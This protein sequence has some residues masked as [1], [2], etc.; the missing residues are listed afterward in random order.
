VRRAAPSPDADLSAQWEVV[1]AFLAASRGGDFQ[2]L[3]AVLDPDVVLRA[4]GGLRAISSHVQGAETVASQ[5]LTWSRV[6]L[7][8]HR[9]LVNG[10]PGFIALRDGRPFS[11]GAFT[12]RG[13]RIVEFDILADPDRLSQLDLTV[14]RD[15][16]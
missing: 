15:S 11:V 14:L 13:G 4:D 8:L 3:V 10:A 7:T 12:V 9:A 5:A 1:D 6:D 2:A 16:R